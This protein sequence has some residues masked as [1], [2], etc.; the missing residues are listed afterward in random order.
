MSQLGALAKPFPKEWIKVKPGKGNAE[1]V[2]HSVITQRLLEVV[3]PFDF[4]VTQVVQQDGDTWCVLA[5]LTC[6][7]DGKWTT[8][9]EGGQ[10]DNKMDPFKSAISDALKRCAMRLGLG[11]HL[12]A[13]ENYYLH[14][15]LSD[16]PSTEGEAD[17]VPEPTTATESTSGSATV[18]PPADEQ[19][20]GDGAAGTSPVAPKTSSEG[21]DGEAPASEEPTPKKEP[22]D[23]A[24]WRATF[25]AITKGPN[26]QLSYDSEVKPFLQAH[27]D[28]RSWSDLTDKEQAALIGRLT[29]GDKDKSQREFADKVRA[30]NKQ[31]AA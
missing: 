11:L 22:A 12:W 3:G 20:D 1:Y 25:M 23:R 14:H 26:C 18:S 16:A 7:V 27:Y 31:D 28:G 15:K 8:I 2:E 13:Q 4:E 10:S 19:P 6:C 24:K 9:V 21:E 5:R 17:P 30:L 29:A